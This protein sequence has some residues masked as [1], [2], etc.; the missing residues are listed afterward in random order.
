M[1]A[2]SIKNVSQEGS[3]FSRNLSFNEYLLQ[4]EKSTELQN[5]AGGLASPKNLSEPRKLE[6]LKQTNQDYYDPEVQHRE[7][8][9]NSKRVQIVHTSFGNDPKKNFSLKDANQKP[10]DSKE[11]EKIQSLHLG[12][13][14]SF[15]DKYNFS[16]KTKSKKQTI[17]EG[18]V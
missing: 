9:D 16:N 11:N 8:V 14:E 12:F 5:I 6:G 10:E 13:K 7:K 1:S 17:N 4:K 15:L 2:R 18:I 3:Q